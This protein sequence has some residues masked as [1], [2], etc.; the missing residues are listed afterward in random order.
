MFHEKTVINGELYWRST[1]DGA[2][3]KYTTAQ[4]SEQIRILQEENEELRKMIPADK[5]SLGWE[6]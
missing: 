2:W 4:L 5:D 3:M 1:P 6:H